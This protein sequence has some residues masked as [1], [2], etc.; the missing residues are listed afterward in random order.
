MR[1]IQLVRLAPLVAGLILART[2][3]AASPGFDEC[4]ANVRKG[5]DSFLAYMCLGTPGLPDRASEVIAALDHVLRRKPAEPH[6]RLYLA[7]MR[8]YGREP[9]REEDF[10][11]PLSALRRRGDPLDVFLAQ[12][13]VLELR[14]DRIVEEC[15][16]AEPILADSERLARSLGE[17]SLLRLAA[18]A[19]I[20]WSTITKSESAALRSE[21]ALDALP[22]KPP[23]WLQLLE[24]NTRARFRF[25][26]G[27]PIKV[28][29]LYAH[30]LEIAPPDSVAH[31]GAL[32]G[33]ASATARLAWEGLAERSEAERLHRQA[34]AAQL[35]LGLRRYNSSEIGS[36]FT[37]KNLAL[38][39]GPTPEARELADPKTPHP[40]A[41]EL[42][43]QGDSQDRALALELARML[44]PDSFNWATVLARSHAE[45]VAGSRAEGVLWGARAIQYSE[46]YRGRE[47]DPELRIAGDWYYDTA[48]KTFAD[49][50]LRTERPENAEV[51][52]AF[53][54]IEQL[55]ARVLLNSLL[56]RTNDGSKQQIPE[57]SELRAAL[58]PDEAL[59][60]FMVSATIPTQ[61]LPYTRGGSWAFVLTKTTLRAVAIPS[62]KVLEPAIKAW[63]RLLEQ[64]HR[65][66]SPGARRLYADVVG[67]VVSVL[68]PEIRS[69]ILVPD[70]P[71]HRLPFDALS[72]SGEPPFLAERYSL[73]VV[74]SA[75]IWLR[76]RQRPPIPPGL[77][78]AFANTPEGPAVKVAETRGEVEPGQLP[79]LLHAWDEAKEA[80]DAFP[81]GSRLFAGA[82]ATPE[83]LAGPPFERASL[84]HFASHGVVNPREPNESFL[85][86]APPGMGSGRLKVSDVE[87]F[88]W[89]G[90]TVVLSACDTSA[91]TFR[92][93][94]GV[95]S[96]A[97]GF[98]AGGASSVLAT[99]SQVRD[100][101]QQA[102]FRAFYAELRRGVS[103]GEAM[104]A[105]KRAVIRS[106]APPAAWAN[107]IVLGDATVRPRAL[108]PTSRW[109]VFVAAVLGAACI[110][111]F[112]VQTSRRRKRGT[113]PKGSSTPGW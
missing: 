90:K 108:E 39:L 1:H 4:L 98:F 47:T 28:R 30:V 97:R 104:T 41:I 73:A 87:R 68:P 65:G 77:A 91:G 21:K 85:L 18:I 24:A 37:Q 61:W 15:A 99:L 72:E 45:F 66:G 58:R 13:A 78:L 7:L 84:V 62:G 44:V 110:A 93:G 63:T 38:L 94:E 96:I 9:Y 54:V 31:A 103:V 52:L 86:L 83:K 80:V 8:L 29:Q 70:G 10:D 16:D 23:P 11:E 101:E 71:V 49:D 2:S 105:A 111:V 113:D 107:V 82:D 67:P 81:T 57:I 59:V 56:A 22:G 25:T 100:D 5:P 20:R 35:K 53:R 89:M 42:L 3:A 17:P 32:A 14:C 50:L 106:G 64:R 6:A 92:L 27:E 55:R 51:A 112:W 36:E 46:D 79:A 19:R 43:L 48:Y 12:L 75:T 109:S 40:L 95:L 74:P 33:Y 76:L 26:M 69:L 88:D 102:L 34:L 60:S